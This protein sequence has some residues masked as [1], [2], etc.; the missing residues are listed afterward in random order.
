MMNQTSVLNHVE[1]DDYQAIELPYQGNETSML[2]ILPDEGKFKEFEN[3][4]DYQKIFDI[5]ASLEDG[6]MNLSMPKFQYES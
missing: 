3:S 2:I 1:G 6:N 5:I 4:L